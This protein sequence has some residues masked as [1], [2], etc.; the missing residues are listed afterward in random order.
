M[1]LY[2]YLTPRLQMSIYEQLETRLVMALLSVVC[3]WIEII[4]V[5]TCSSEA[6]LSRCEIPSSLFVL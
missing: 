6:H 5:M 4:C 3:V 1:P 2:L